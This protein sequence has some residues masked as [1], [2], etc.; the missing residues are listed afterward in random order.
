ML[1]DG[2]KI[3]PNTDVNSVRRFILHCPNNKT[4]KWKTLDAAELFAQLDFTNKQLTKIRK[5]LRHFKKH[6]SRFGYIEHNSKTTNSTYFTLSYGYGEPKYFH[7][8]V[9]DH[10]STCYYITK[11]YINKS[12]DACE[13]KSEIKRWMN[14]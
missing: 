12:V 11:N 5:V 13:L 3:E 7:I 1:P 10:K 2:Y 6:H 14:N 9:S 8:R 4:K